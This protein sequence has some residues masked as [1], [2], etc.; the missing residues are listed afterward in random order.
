MSIAPLLDRSS[1]CQSYTKPVRPL[2]LIVTAGPTREPIDLVRYISNYSTG[3]MGYEIVN[4]AKNRG[5]IVVL[6]S[7][8]T[9]L[10][11]PKCDKTILVESA[12]QMRQAILFEIRKSDALIMAAAVCDWRVARKRRS[13]IKKGST[14]VILKLKENPDILKDVS[15]MIAKPSRK[16]PILVGFALETEGLLRNARKKL[17]EKGLDLIIGNL[18]SKKN[19]PFGDTKGDFLMIDRYENIKTYR[20]YSKTELAIRIIDKV[21]SLCYSSLRVE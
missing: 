3:R 2:R 15:R 14:D 21:E 6:I 5:H 4:V 7:G 9:H 20:R 16:R 11:F 13:K 12:S 10:L 17:K 18:L 1:S 8:P 19:Y